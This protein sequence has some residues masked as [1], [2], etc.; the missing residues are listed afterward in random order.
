MG[1]R[2][3]R[4]GWLLAAGWS[5]AVTDAAVLLPP[6]M[7]WE[8]LQEQLQSTHWKALILFCRLFCR[9]SI[10]RSMLCLEA[11]AFERCGGSVPCAG[12]IR[13]GIVEDGGRL[14]QCPGLCGVVCCWVCR[15]GWVD[16]PSNL[17]EGQQRERQCLPRCGRGG[18]LQDACRRVEPARRRRW[19]QRG[20][21][22]WR[23]SRLRGPAQGKRRSRRRE[24]RERL[25][26]RGS[27]R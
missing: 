3:N 19:T 23:W 20:G 15:C 2:R 17:A 24:P 18:F 25:R 12:T 26:G 13:L 8:A 5:A 14:G 27:I 6:M 1:S 9:L 22:T 11:S 16:S 4:F 10:S 21:S 7:V